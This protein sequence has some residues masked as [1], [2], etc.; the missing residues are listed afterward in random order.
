MMRG[1]NMKKSK[2]A[3]IVS[4]IFVVLLIGGIGCLFF[5]PKFYDFFKEPNV[6][7]FASH[8]MY[9]KV[10]FY[11]CYIICLIIIYNLTK[12]FNHVYS[13]SPFRQE[14]V[15][16]LNISAILF[17]IL[18]GIVFVKALFIPTLLSFVVALVCFI[19]SLSFY[20]LKEVIKA[21]IIY[22]NEIDYTV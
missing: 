11:S 3:K 22:K 8:S 18:A 21:A 17:M 12:L 6:S 19:V 5:I 7:S 14:V 13:S 20:V 15:S 16:A 4:V 10:A 9:Y 1:V 2:I